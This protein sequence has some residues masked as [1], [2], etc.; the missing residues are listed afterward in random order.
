[1]ANHRFNPL[2]EPIITKHSLDLSTLTSWIMVP[3]IN[4][5]GKVHG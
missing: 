5:S 2:P 3:S 1:M 4:V